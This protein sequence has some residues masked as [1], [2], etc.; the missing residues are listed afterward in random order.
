M[1]GICCTAG[2]V[3]AGG[4]LRLAAVLIGGSLVVARAAEIGVAAGSIAAP[5]GLEGRPLLGLA[6]VSDTCRQ[7]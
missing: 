7:Q 3:G 2:D 6:S 1:K 5:A 4:C